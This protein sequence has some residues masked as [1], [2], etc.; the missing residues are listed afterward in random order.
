MFDLNMKL[1]K[2]GL[3]HFYKIKLNFVMSNNDLARIDSIL[4]SLKT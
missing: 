3:Y 4:V 2:I 1:V